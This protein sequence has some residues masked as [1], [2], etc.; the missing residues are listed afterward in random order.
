MDAGDECFVE[1]LDAVGG[2]H[3]DA[4]E[5]LKAAEE[6]CALVS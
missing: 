5:V 4:F 6:D 3:E 1:L 2:E